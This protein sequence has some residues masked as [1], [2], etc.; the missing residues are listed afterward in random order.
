MHPLFERIMAGESVS[1][2]EISEFNAN[3]IMDWVRHGGHEPEDCQDRSGH[4]CCKASGD[5]IELA[6]RLA[7]HE[8]CCGV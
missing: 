2:C 1:Q 7:N 6:A 4:C 3:W 5:D 8:F